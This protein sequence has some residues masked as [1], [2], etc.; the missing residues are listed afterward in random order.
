MRKPLLPAAGGG[1]HTYGQPRAAA[2]AAAGP[3]VPTS[4]GQQVRLP[5][6][7]LQLVA[8][9]ADKVVL[10]A[11]AGGRGGTVLGADRQ[12]GDSR[13]GYAQADASAPRPLTLRLVD[14]A[15]VLAAEALVILQGGH[16]K[17]L[18][19]ACLAGGGPGRSSAPTAHLLRLL[20]HCR[21][22]AG[23]S[24][25]WKSRLPGCQDAVLAFYAG[26]K[27]EWRAVQSCI[28]R[29]YMP[30][31][32][33]STRLE[34]VQ[35]ARSRRGGFH[36]DVPPRQARCCT[37]LTA[38]SSCSGL[39]ALITQQ[40]PLAADMATAWRWGGPCWPLRES[41]ML[42]HKSRSPRGHACA[43]SA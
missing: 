24:A 15:S 4:A 22:A 29:R 18:A 23:G 35:Q 39:T 6:N 16:P 13:S 42:S 38:R 14:E 20:R 43:T 5:D 28:E 7:L 2:G 33:A 30:P 41:F 21:S 11:C 12:A 17:P 40:H 26:C 27:R 25:P 10:V 34:L 36:H 37:L 19:T 8:I 32:L 9:C 3:S 1:P 31:E